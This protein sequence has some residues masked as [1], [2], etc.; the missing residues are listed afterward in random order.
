MNAPHFPV[1]LPQVLAALDPKPNEVFID[2]TLGAGGYASAILKREPRQLFGF[3]R[4]LSAFD[5]WKDLYGAPPKNLCFCHAP[6]GTMVDTLLAKGIQNVD[7][8]VLDLGVSSMQLDQEHRGFS[9]GKDGPLDMRMD[10]SHGVTAAEVVNNFDQGAIADILW[11]FGEERKSRQIAKAIIERRL[12]KPFRSTLDLA[13]LIR[14][15]VHQRPGTKIDPATRSFQGLRIFVNDELGELGRALMAAETLLDDGGRL[16]VVS[17][18]SL[19]DR[20]VKRFLKDRNGKMDMGSRHL[21]VAAAA[22]PKQQTF[23]ALSTKV[24]KPSLAE[25]EQNP[26]SRSAVMR[27]AVRVRNS[28]KQSRLES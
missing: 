26:R 11:K 21:P 4:D 17:F 5:L 6:F 8:I 25:C 24:I 18:H 3:D 20:I 27:A 28:A 2:G 23:R 16:V 1:M 15:V 13:D 22:G 10:Q 12:E 14:R 9:F 19:E 7:G